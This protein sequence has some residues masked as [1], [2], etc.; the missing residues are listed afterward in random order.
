MKIGK[1]GQGQWVE[2]EEQV[3]TASGTVITVKTRKWQGAE[4]TEEKKKK[5]HKLHDLS[6]VFTDEMRSSWGSQGTIALTERG[7]FT[8]QNGTIGTVQPPDPLDKQLAPADNPDIWARNNFDCHTLYDHELYIRCDAAVGL[9]KNQHNSPPRTIV[10]E[11]LESLS[12][13]SSSENEK[14]Q[15]ISSTDPSEAEGGSTDV[16]GQST[17]RRSTR[18]ELS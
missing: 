15:Q 3:T 11:Y 7:I 6:S 9:D 14:N 2:V 10:R 16:D 4:K 1:K 8:F 18:K 5:K 12:R 17:R 13:G